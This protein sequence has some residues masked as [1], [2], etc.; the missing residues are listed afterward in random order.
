M[1]TLEIRSRARKF[2]GKQFLGV[3][4]RNT[5][6]KSLPRN[7]D[8]PIV[9]ICNTH[10]LSK[11]GE[12]WVSMYINPIDCTGEFFCSLGLPPLDTFVRFMNHFCYNGW[13]RNSKQL[14]SA[15]SKFCGHYCIFYCA[16][17]MLNLDMQTI[18]NCFSDDVSLNDYIAH[19][20]ACS[21][22]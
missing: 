12:H 6:P 22:Y 4:A 18:I 16:H 20:F 5:L 8:R 13:I 15:V 9:L 19:S 11:P 10:E 3:F 1:N 14:Q 7:L 17:K 2:C 21:Y